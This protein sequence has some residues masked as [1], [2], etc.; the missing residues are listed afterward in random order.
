MSLK[1]NTTWSVPSQPKEEGRE[2]FFITFAAQS[3]TVNSLQHKTKNKRDP[4]K[5]GLKTDMALAR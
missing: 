3:E 1:L 2:G 5:L 4:N